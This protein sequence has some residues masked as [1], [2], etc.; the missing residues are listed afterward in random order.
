MV[1]NFKGNDMTQDELAAD[2]IDAIATSCEVAFTKL[3]LQGP[4]AKRALADLF[5][6]PAFQ[7]IFGLAAA[8]A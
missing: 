4:E 6:D 5:S 3:E 1:T 7:A 2:A 8:A